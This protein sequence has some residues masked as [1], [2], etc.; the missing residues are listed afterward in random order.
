VRKKR[1]ARAKERTRADLVWDEVEVGCCEEIPWFG[2]T[3]ERRFGDWGEWIRVD[4]LG[5]GDEELQGRRQ[6]E[7]EG[8]RGQLELRALRSLHL[9]SSHP[10]FERTGPSAGI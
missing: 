3:K 10:T 4:R 5:Q 7:K 8:R 2:E 1:R 9:S 6:G